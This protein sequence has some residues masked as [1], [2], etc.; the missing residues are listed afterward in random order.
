MIITSCLFFFFRLFS[1]LPKFVRGCDHVVKFFQCEKGKRKRL[2]SKKSRNSL[3]KEEVLDKMKQKEFDTPHRIAEVVREQSLGESER[4]CKKSENKTDTN[5]SENR[6]QRQ[7]D[8]GSPAVIQVDENG[9]ELKAS[10]SGKIINSPCSV[11]FQGIT[12]DCTYT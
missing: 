9:N 10:A 2:E 7:A 1:S 5:Q 4:D 12:R 11:G 6:D 8:E 3:K